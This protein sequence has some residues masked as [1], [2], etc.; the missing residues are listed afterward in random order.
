MT[1]YFKVKIDK[2][3]YKYDINL[4]EGNTNEN[5]PQIKKILF[6]VKE[7]RDKIYELFGQHFLL[8][9]NSIYTL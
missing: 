7:N 8:L 4:T 5:F 9:N 1:N 6:G 2:E 3:I